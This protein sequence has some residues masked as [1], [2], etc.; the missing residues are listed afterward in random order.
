MNRYDIQ[1]AIRKA[2]TNQRKIAREIGVDDTMVYK[3]VSGVRNT[4]WV[5]QAISV[6]IGIPVRKLWKT[7]AR[8][9]RMQARGSA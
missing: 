1:A 6:R 7:S 3:T 5:Q 4:L 2:G 8:P 9:R